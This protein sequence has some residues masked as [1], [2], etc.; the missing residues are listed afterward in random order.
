VALQVFPNASPS[1]ALIRSGASH[2]SVD[3]HSSIS[4][5]SERE[6]GDSVTTDGDEEWPNLRGPFTPL[7]VRVPPFFVFSQ[8]AI[9]TDL[10]PEE[11]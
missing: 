2:S 1:T 10:C 9:L 8:R 5:F 6:S 3:S 7:E 11:V 4:S